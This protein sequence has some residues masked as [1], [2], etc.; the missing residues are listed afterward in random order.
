M[1]NLARQ[2]IIIP[3]VAQHSGI[4]LRVAAYC[5][6]STDSEDQKNSFSAQN[7]YY[8]T[9]ISA[10]ENWQLVDI[11]AD[12]GI[13]GTS[14]QK[15]KDFQRLL[16]D[17][18]RGLIDKVLVK[19]VSR[20]AR[21]TKECLEAIRELKSLG[22]S[23][24]FEEQ[25]I[26]TKTASSELMTAVMAALAQ[27]ESESISRNLTWSI[28]K[29]MQEGTY[30]A[31]HAPFGYRRVKGHL[32]IH[33]EEAEYIRFLALQYLAGQNADDLAALMKKKS[34][35]DP[36]LQ[37]RNW[38]RRTIFQILRNEKLVGD[39]LHKK[40]YGTDTL[41][42]KR[43]KNRG[44]RDRYY[45]ANTHPAILD[46]KTYDAL[47]SL[48]ARRGAGHPLTRK[49]A[50]SFSSIT[51]CGQCGAPCRCL[52]CRGKVY[53]VCRT[54]A[55]NKD[56][57]N[58]LQ[59]PEKELQKAFCRM[60]DKLKQNNH[61][62]IASMLRDLSAAKNRQML[63]NADI[64]TLNKEISDIQ[65]QSHTLA[66]LNQ[67]GLVDS[68]IFISQSNQLAQQLHRAKTE[69]A[70]LLSQVQDSTIE[71]TQEIL[72]T[73]ETGPEFLDAF[74]PDLLGELV[75]KIIVY[76]RTKIGFLLLNGLELPETI[77]RTVR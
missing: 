38:T 26:D 77:E 2:K 47:S 16:S 50:S 63:W 62:V 71:K 56:N 41:P 29:K 31:P 32:V 6:V 44:E 49:K 9:L 19:S 75:G 39:T 8:T 74:D 33:E 54:H 5:R 13:T 42:R 3:A 10:M 40:T 76:S 60:Y 17:C 58:V 46:Q 61:A 52:Q 12:E 51:V 27:A 48:I 25:H 69:K 20:F 37:T 53:L 66:V 45:V 18:R 36:L 59:V 22:I 57:C 30:V 11:Y 28:Q 70:R 64:I 72:E 65:T 43:L 24:Q 23:V 1:D 34:I 73:L 14:T 15:R 4:K 55:N 35:E 21:N 68:G 67:K 7:A